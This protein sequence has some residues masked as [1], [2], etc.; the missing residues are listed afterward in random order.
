MI[1]NLTIVLLAATIAA[2]T[3]T[4]AAQSLNSGLRGPT[5]LNDEGAAAPMAPRATR[6]SGKSEIT[7]NSRR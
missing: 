3:G 7:Q 1:R 6:R 5:P 4:L 2:G